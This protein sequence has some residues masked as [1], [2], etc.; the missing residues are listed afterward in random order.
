MQAVAPPRLPLRH[1][2]FHV[3]RILVPES[4]ELPRRQHKVIAVMPAYNA[5]RTLAATLADVP[6]GSVDEVIL[7]DDG[8]KDQT[9]RLAREMGLTVLQHPKNRGYGGNQK[10]CYRTALEHGAD[11]VVMIHP[12]YQYDS[13]VIPHAVGIIEL[14]ICDV[15]LG[16]RIRSRQEALAGGMPFWK[17]LCNR[18]LTI[19]ENMALGQNLGDFH[20]GFRVYRREVLERIPF[21]RNSDDFVFDTQFLAQ[22]VR[23]GF[24]L[25]DIP[26]PVR[27]FDE[28]SSINFRRSLRYGLSTLTVLVQYWLDRLRL[29]RSPLF[30]E[31]PRPAAAVGRA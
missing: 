24:R 22:A 18:F 8:S 12:D 13:R 2:F 15:V 21:E 23:L 28:A 6:V 7:V 20:S 19:V 27:Y 14:G 9:V 30:R 3:D 26:V 11:I 31:K 25:G 29:W 5:E 4:N 16:S 17:Y 1:E 10:T